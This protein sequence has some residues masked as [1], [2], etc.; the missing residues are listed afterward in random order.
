MASVELEGARPNNPKNP[1]KKNENF[2]HWL[3]FADLR[4]NQTKQKKEIFWVVREFETI[5]FRLYSNTKLDRA[6]FYWRW[7]AA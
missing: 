2:I 1:S 4:Q 3:A 6:Y 7:Q 5:Q